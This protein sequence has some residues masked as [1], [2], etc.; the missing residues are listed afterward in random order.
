MK[1][2]NF[3]NWC[4]GELSKILVIK[5]FKNLSYQKMSKTTNVFPNLYFSMNKK[6]EIPIIFD[7]EN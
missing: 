5:R 7:I 6:F 3:E 2:P 4:C 1:L